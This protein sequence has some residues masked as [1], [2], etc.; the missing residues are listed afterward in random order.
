MHQ[1]STNSQRSKNA[2]LETPVLQSLGQCPLHDWNHH[3]SAKGDSST[4]LQMAFEH[5]AWL[6]STVVDVLQTQQEVLHPEC[7][8]RRMHKIAL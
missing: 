4:T 2:L 8:P 7:C 1:P 5:L 6:G 3:L